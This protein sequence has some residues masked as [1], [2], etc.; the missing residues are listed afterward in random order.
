[1]KKNNKGFTLIELLVVVAIIGILAAMILPALGKA[2]EKAK[3]TTCKNN[4]KQLGTQVAMYYTDGGSNSIPEPT[5]SSSA[6]ASSTAVTSKFVLWAIEHS[7]MTCPV[8]STS[9]YVWNLGNS[10]GVYS[11]NAD[12]N[13]ANDVT[14]GTLYHNIDPKTQYLWQD[15]HV[16]ATNAP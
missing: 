12:T 15:G 7:I 2:R 13:L 10:G 6:L 16:T 5:T 1:M 3:I 11:G 14:T 8:K 4:L 9:T